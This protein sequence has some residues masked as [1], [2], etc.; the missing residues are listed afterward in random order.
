V[1]DTF[2]TDRRPRQSAAVALLP[3]N[4]AVRACRPYARAVQVRRP[5][6]TGITEGA[7]KAEYRLLVDTADLG[8]AA[9]VIAQVWDDPALASRSL[10]RAYTHFGNPTFGAY[11][12]GELSGVCVGFLALTGGVHLHSHI[13]GVLPEYQHLGIG[14]AL[15]R[16]QRE[17][18]LRNG[19]D[20]VTWTVDPLLARNAHFN[21]RKLR[22]VATAI[23]PNFYGQM[24][25]AF[26]K[27]DDTDRL[28]MHWDIATTRV[29]STIDGQPDGGTAVE[30]ARTVSIPV[31]YLRLRAEDPEKARSERVR[32]RDELEDAFGH[33]LVIVDFEDGRYCFAT[34]DALAAAT[35]D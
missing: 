29:R 1:P 26:N 17:W 19:I 12:D 5:S 31:D 8:A 24:N 3:P 34:R 6:A 11:V 18:C 32:V 4:K 13:T 33:G 20:E 9:D 25:D 15:K 10:L 16:E 21:V 2:R 23:L 7:S 35:D 30:V 14:F 27:G 28:E 22:A